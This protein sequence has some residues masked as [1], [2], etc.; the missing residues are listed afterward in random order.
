[1]AKSKTPVVPD[2]HVLRVLMEEYVEILREAERR[3]R[4]ALSLDPHQEEFWDEL[5]ELDPHLTFVA[6]RT[7][8]I[9]EEIDELTEQLP[10]D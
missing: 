5:S 8:S 1:M 4:K 9:Q 7:E 6:S 3:T 2:T 10:G